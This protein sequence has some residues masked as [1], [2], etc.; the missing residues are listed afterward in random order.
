MK[1]KKSNWPIPLIKHATLIDIK[2][3]GDYFCKRIQLGQKTSLFSPHKGQVIIGDLKFKFYKRR[4]NLMRYRYIL[5]IFEED[6]NA[7][8]AK[9]NNS[10]PNNSR[11]DEYIYESKIEFNSINKPVKLKLLTQSENQYV[12]SLS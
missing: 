11:M 8:S 9:N 5:E 6:T 10:Q 1:D 3:G 4:V 7:N 2:N 12:F